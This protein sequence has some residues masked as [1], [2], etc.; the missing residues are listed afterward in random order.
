MFDLKE[1][2]I[3]R[4]KLIRKRIEQEF[5]SEDFYFCPKISQ[6]FY[7]FGLKSWLLTYN[8]ET[9]LVASYSFLRN[10]L[11]DVT[12]FVFEGAPTIG[13]NF[14]TRL[15]QRDMAIK[16]IDKWIPTMQTLISEQGYEEIKIPSIYAFHFP[17]IYYPLESFTE[18]EALANNVG[19]IIDFV[20]ETLKIT[21]EGGDLL[22]DLTDKEL[23]E[24]GH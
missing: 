3:R 12:K 6:E 22:K 5:A 21:K 1:L 18:E 20:S 16:I 4:N 13:F 9:K 7:Y 14:E 8:E 15:I 19:S 17:N 24:L 10:V 23:K 2:V 11:K